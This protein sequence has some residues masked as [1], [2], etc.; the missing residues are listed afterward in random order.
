MANGFYLTEFF[1]KLIPS[2]SKLVMSYLKKHDLNY[3]D[4]TDYACCLMDEENNIAAM[5]CSAGNILKGFA[6]EARYRGENLLGRLIDHLL[7]NRLQS[8]ITDLFVFT[9]T[10]HVAL[11]ENSGFYLLV[12]TADVAML[13]NSYSGVSNFIS[14]LGIPQ[15]CD[16]DVVGS[17]VMNCN[18]FSLGHRYLIEYASQNCDKLYIFVVEEDKSVFPFDVRFKLIK[19]GVSDLGNVYVFPSGHYIISSS[20]FPTYFLKENSDAAKIHSEIDVSLFAEKIARPLHITKRFVG[21]EPRCPVTSKYNNAMKAFLPKY[22]IEVIEIPRIESQDKEIISASII[23]KKLAQC[24]PGEWLRDYVPEV[25]YS[26]LTH[27]QAKEIIDM[28]K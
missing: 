18:P 9:K 17:I 16:G 22:G 12:Q 14:T 25:T 23:R 4:D 5:G 28:C 27:E 15:N 3:E 2:D 10:E 1:P 13:E 7:Q 21:E 20:T 11:F 6:V 26:Y 24:G 8:G 19:E